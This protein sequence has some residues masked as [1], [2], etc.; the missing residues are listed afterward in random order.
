M[1]Q[2]KW[3]KILDVLGACT[4]AQEWASNYGTFLEAWKACDRVDWMWWLVSQFAYMDPPIIG[5]AKHHRLGEMAREGCDAMRKEM[6]KAPKFFAYFV[7]VA[8]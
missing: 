6:G 7:E 8:K 4:E 5:E 1:E 3:V 2:P